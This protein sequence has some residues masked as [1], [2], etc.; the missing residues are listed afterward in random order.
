M[1]RIR[2]SEREGAWGGEVTSEEKGDGRRERFKG[3]GR[4]E[5][6][7]Q[8]W[9]RVPRSGRVHTQERGVGILEPQDQDGT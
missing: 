2:R 9:V 7:A 4:V 3:A 6:G 8:I 1:Q 5:G